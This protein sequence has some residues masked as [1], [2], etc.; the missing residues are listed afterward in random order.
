MKK[1][2]NP[3]KIKIGC[4]DSRS[5]GYVHIDIDP[6][7]NP[8]IT[9]D[10]Q[11]MFMIKDNSVEEIVCEMVMEHIP[12]TLKVMKEFHRVLKPN[13]ILK[14]VT[15]HALNVNL[16]SVPDHIKGFTYTTFN[17]FWQS[18]HLNYPK[19]RCKKRRITTRNKHMQWLPDRF[20][21]VAERLFWLIQLDG[22]EAEL[23]AIK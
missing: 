20:P 13:G 9:A 11:N 22:I 18:G 1:L 19:F 8:D 17:Q 5:D 16:Y 15:V 4:M 2:I 6:A 12:D 10:C 7:T 14:I 3:R 21:L 23:E